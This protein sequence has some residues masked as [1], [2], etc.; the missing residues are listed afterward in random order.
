MNIKLALTFDPS[1]ATYRVALDEF[2]K[3]PEARPRDT[4]SRRTE[5]QQLYDKARRAEHDGSMLQ[6]IQLLEQALAAS[7]QAVFLNRLA[8][9]LA[10]KQRDYRR[11]QK[12]LEEAVKMRPGN[13]TYARNLK[14]IGLLINADKQVSSRAGDG[15][16]GLFGGLL[17]RFGGSKN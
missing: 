1:N 15:K 16:R 11:A 6:A 5:A 8:L 12:Y 7:R 3:M 13:A 14:R 9:I 4:A 2:E 17:S 10:D